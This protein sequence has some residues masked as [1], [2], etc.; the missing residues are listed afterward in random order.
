MLSGAESGEDSDA[1]ARSESSRLERTEAKALEARTQPAPVIAAEVPVMDAA[2]V[3]LAG[4]IAA[5]L[6]E[7]VA[8]IEPTV[9]VAPPAP[10]AEAPPD[11]AA[12]ALPAPAVAAPPDPGPPSL[13]PPKVV[14]RVPLKIGKK[15]RKKKAHG[16]KASQQVKAEAAVED[17]PS[18]I[19]AV[20]PPEEGLVA[21]STDLVTVRPG[22]WVGYY[23][24]TL[25][26][27]MRL[28][29]AYRL[30]PENSQFGFSFTT[31]L[32][33][34]WL[35]HVKGI[36]LMYSVGNTWVKEWTNRRLRRWMIPL[37]DFDPLDVRYGILACG[38]DVC[39]DHMAH[40]GGCP[41]QNTKRGCNMFHIRDSGFVMSGL[42]WNNP[43]IIGMISPL[44]RRLPILS[45]AGIEVS[46]ETQ[47]LSGPSA[48]QSRTTTVSSRFKG[49]R[50]TR[51]RR[52]TGPAWTRVGSPT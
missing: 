43:E 10:A 3:V 37:D 1:R 34:Y 20:T 28:A 11:L 6:V 22:K 39:S 12:V 27:E 8:A 17:A 33:E 36:T 46:A 52:R 49:G 35:P 50:P 29:R 25:A 13:E 14:G 51:P 48:S 7:P 32:V 41:R 24:S 18:G 42:P 9:V 15:K 5:V 31:D 19:V 21:P 26:P 23:E 30:L 2:P 45:K 16:T 47:K 4:P 38:N 40:E 44:Q